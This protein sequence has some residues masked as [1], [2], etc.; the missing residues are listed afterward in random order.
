M[1]LT[2]EQ[3][4]IVEEN[5]SLI[6]WYLHK[7]NLNIEDW[8]DLL[9]IELCN[10]VM[11]HDASRGSLANYFKLRCDGVVSKEYRKSKSL[12]RAHEKIRY[13]ENVHGVEDPFDLTAHIELKEIL[14]GPYG[15]LLTMKYEGYTQTEMAKELGISQT[16]VSK[17]LRQLREDWT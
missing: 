15:K 9:A 1:R 8:Y 6:F 5:H 13:V 11:K 7:M 4:K 12:K 17:M 2:E 14:N 3:A 10:S 16:Y